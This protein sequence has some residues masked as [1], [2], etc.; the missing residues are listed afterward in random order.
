[1]TQNI[2]LTIKF[3]LNLP[4]KNGTVFTQDAVHNA[5]AEV[6]A[7]PMPIIDYTQDKMGNVVGAAT[8][9]AYCETYNSCS[10]SNDCFFFNDTCLKEFDME[11]MINK[12]HKNQD[13][14]IIIDDFRIMSMSIV[15]D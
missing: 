4:N 12:S 11:Y 5:F 14:T 3:P 1:M 10:I 6:K 8:P 15:E 7:I 13:G 9:S 2:N